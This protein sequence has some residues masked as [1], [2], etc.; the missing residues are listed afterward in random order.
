VNVRALSDAVGAVGVVQ[1]HDRVLIGSVAIINDCATS[2]ELP[3]GF[4]RVQ[5]LR[6]WYDYEI[7]A[8]AAG[9]LLDDGDIEI[10]RAAGTTG[11]AP[12]PFGKPFCP[13]NVY[14]ALNDFA[15]TS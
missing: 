13:Q 1:C 15:A 9:V 8:R 4:Y 12:D 14:F 2:S 6:A 3:V 7:G 11:Y 5:V 10:S